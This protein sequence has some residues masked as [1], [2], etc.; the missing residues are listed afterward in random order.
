MSKSTTITY[1]ALITLGYIW[2]GIQLVASEP[3]DAFVLFIVTFFLHSY[4]NAVP[5][6]SNV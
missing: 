5:E 6:Q 1:F 4:R 2:A 3:F